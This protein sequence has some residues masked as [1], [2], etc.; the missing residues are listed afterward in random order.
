MTFPYYLIIVFLGGLLGCFFLFFK[1]D[2]PVYLKAFGPFLLITLIV[3]ALGVYLS[4]KATHT[5]YIYNLF[6]IVEACFYLWVLKNVIK[7]PLIR[8]VLFYTL[9]IFPALCI[10]NMLFIQKFRSFNSITYALGCLLIIFFSIYFFFE[11]FKVQHSVKLS[12]DPA[13][14]ICTALLFFY[15]CTFP[16]FVASNFLNSIPLVIKKNATVIITLLNVLL[17][18]LFIIAFL[19]RI[20][21][22]KPS[23]SVQ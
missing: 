5:L 19:C 7:D 8:K 4:S 11:L 1:K 13:F 12:A 17:Y 2:S 10:I 15:S 22:K 9:I 23:L 3:D 14:W 18:S 20:R 6:S 16:L 21:A